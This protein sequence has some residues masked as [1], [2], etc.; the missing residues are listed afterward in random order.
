MG[1]QTKKSVPGIR[2]LGTKRTSASGFADVPPVSHD[3]PTA[4]DGIFT[5]FHEKILR[6]GGGL[7]KDSFGQGKKISEDDSE[8]DSPDLAA[9]RSDSWI[10]VR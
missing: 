9:R 7:Q 2:F 5:K 4:R 8:N 3:H 1:W 10:A 6:Q